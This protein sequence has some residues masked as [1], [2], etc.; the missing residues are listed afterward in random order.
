MINDNVD[1][2]YTGKFYPLEMK[3][4]VIKAGKTK[5]GRVISEDTMI[6]SF[7]HE[8]GHLFTHINGYDDL[9]K[10]EKFCDEMGYFLHQLIQGLK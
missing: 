2:D 4:E 6:H 1:K 5:D 3:I 9:Y 7:L 8:L 10:D